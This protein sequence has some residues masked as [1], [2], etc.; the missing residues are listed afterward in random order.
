MMIVGTQSDKISSSNTK[1]IEECRSQLDFIAS[2]VERFSSLLLSSRHLDRDD[3][4][5]SPSFRH[6]LRD[7]QHRQHDEG[8]L[9]DGSLSSNKIRTRSMMVSSITQSRVR[10][11]MKSIIDMSRDMFQSSRPPSMLPRYY[12]DAEKS[13][14]DPDQRMIEMMNRSPFISME[15]IKNQGLIGREF[16]ESMAEWLHNIG[17]IVMSPSREMMCLRPQV[18]ADLM[19]EFVCSRSHDRI[20]HRV[21]RWSSSSSSSSS[22]QQDHHHHHDEGDPEGHHDHDQDERSDDRWMM[23]ESE[24]VA[25]VRSVFDRSGFDQVGM[26]FVF[27]FD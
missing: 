16:D 4:D 3:D 8:G 13:L 17:V 2:S 22:S 25:R 9:T 24:C 27:V 20:R 7:S 11:L 21:S 26:L 15:E 19:S 14:E 5:V 18:L 1:A 10:D 12:L 23:K 6:F